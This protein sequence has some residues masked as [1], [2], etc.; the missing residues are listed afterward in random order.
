MDYTLLAS[1]LVR[2]LRGGRSQ[3]AF[4]RRLGYKSNVVYTW[5]S[6]RGAPTAAGMLQAAR[7]IGIDLSAVYGGF[8]RSPPDWLQGRDPAT[9]SGVAAFLNDLRG[10][11]SIV[12]LAAYTGKSRFAIARWMKGETEP[13]LPDFLRLIEATSL[14][15][16]DFLEQLVD[17]AQ[18]P[19]IRERWLAITAA[20]RL[21]YEAPWTQALLRALE[22]QEYQQGPHRE[23]WLASRIGI[24][25][26]IE[27]ASLEQLRVA[28][29][30]RWAIER[31]EIVEV[32]ALDTRKDRD[33]A[34][35]LKVWWGQVGLE[36]VAAGHRGM[37][38]NLFG[39]S[40]AD[41]QRLRELQRAYFNEVRTLVAQSQ[42]VQHVG[43]A[44]VLLVDLAEGSGL[45]PL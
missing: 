24:S 33:A 38:Y 16:V 9:V 13:K 23:G 36:R 41:L 20:R 2:A 15:L 25:L 5:E 26:D 17:P 1:E 31:W 6:G 43:L 3:P 10:H 14:R 44:G 22:L 42:P 4:S 34:L 32:L 39:V 29:Q 21:A 18:L 30:I 45:D 37:V 11:T 35:K 8:Y 40:T 27:I 7:R 28:G 12:D 19:S